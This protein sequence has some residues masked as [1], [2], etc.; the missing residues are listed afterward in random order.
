MQMSKIRTTGISPAR[1]SRSLSKF[2]GETEQQ[3]R[4]NGAY[5]FRC[6]G[7]GEI[8]LRP[9]TNI[10]N[11][12]DDCLGETLEECLKAQTKDNLDTP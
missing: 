12:T 3:A 1:F 10:T 7:S 11:H 9:A 5:S 8:I 4:S 6:L 2:L